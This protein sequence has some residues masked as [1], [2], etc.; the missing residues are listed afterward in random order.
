MNFRGILRVPQC[1]EKQQYLSR[2]EWRWYQ[3]YLAQDLRIEGEYIP[4]EE[5]W[6]FQEHQI[7][8]DRYT[9]NNPKAKILLF[10][11]GGGNGRVLGAFARM[12]MRAGCLVV[13]PDFPG[14]GLT[15]RSSMIKPTYALWSKIGSALIDAEHKK[16]ELPVIVWGLSI[17]GF[18]AYMAAAEN[19]KV[20][21]LIATTLA[22]TRRIG[23]MAKVGRNSLLGG[24]GFLLAKLFGPLIDPIRL[25][26]KWVAPMELI[27][28]DPDVSRV[29]MKD[30]LAGGANATMGFLRSLIYAKPALEPEN[31][32]VCPVLLAHPA[33][34]PWTPLELSM[35]FFDRIKSKKE[36]VVLEGCGHFPVEEPGRFQLEDALAR[37]V[38]QITDARLH[39]AQATSTP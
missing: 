35:K 6:C 31:F 2:P 39:Y 25:P 37:F 26:M 29:F 8:L 21:G 27:T 14:Y 20:D 17:G 3:K 9:V 22:D 5:W 1:G 11:G 10:H 13:A 30:K 34:D 23:T 19:Q 38:S 24:G 4:T 28:N 7:H 32:N 36:L 18:L 12:A 33:V 16:D 15:V